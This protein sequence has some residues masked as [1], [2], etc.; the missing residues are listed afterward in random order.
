MRLLP[1][2][3]LVLAS[4]PAAAAPAATA[5]TSGLVAA[6][7]AAD[8]SLASGSSKL[9]RAEGDRLGGL[10]NRSVLGRGFRAHIAPKVEIT[11][12]DAT[13]DS[14]LAAAEKEF[15]GSGG[16]PAD[17]YES[18]HT[19]R[20]LQGESRVRSEP[21]LP[22]N[23]LGVYHEKGFCGGTVGLN[24]LLF[25]I[26]AVIPEKLAALVAF[27]EIGHCLNPRHGVIASEIPAFRLQCRMLRFFDPSGELVGVVSRGIEL[28]M[29]DHGPDRVSLQ[30]ERYLRQ[31][32]AL[33]GTDCQT[34]AIRRFVYEDGYREG[35]GKID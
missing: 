16:A 2:L 28:Q 12:R 24:P 23:D 21:L 6:V 15:A 11:Y 20:R 7:Q 29:E 14:L 26:G 25:K 32:N 22:D 8:R 1:A 35:L 33:S 9:V 4:G 3:L 5:T 27:H 19:L 10:L 18:L 34:D 30:A 13:L 17:F 31:L